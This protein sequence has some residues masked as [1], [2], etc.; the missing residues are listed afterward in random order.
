MTG[1]ENEMQAN[2]MYFASKRSMT[3]WW[4][5]TTVLIC[6][7]VGVNVSTL[8]P[9]LMIQIQN[10]LHMSHAHT[11]LHCL[12]MTLCSYPETN[13]TSPSRRISASEIVQELVGGNT[14]P[15]LQTMLLH[16]LPNLMS[17]CPDICKWRSNG[18]QAPGGSSL[19]NHHWTSGGTGPLN[20][21]VWSSPYCL[22][23]LPW[24]VSRGKDSWQP[25]QTVGAAG[26]GVHRTLACSF[27]CMMQYAKPS[28]GMF[29]RRPRH[30]TYRTSYRVFEKEDETTDD[31]PTLSTTLVYC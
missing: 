4:T 23:P 13:T 6:S 3:T 27:W 14:T 31:C 22:C 29:D 17:L 10:L 21:G 26:L 28:P 15:V 2:R 12:N 25:L 9:L 8:G 18:E 11:Q 24:G 1:N 30:L 16:T 7:I 5:T 19:S 20:W